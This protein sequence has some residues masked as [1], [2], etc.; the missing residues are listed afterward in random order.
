MGAPTPGGLEA[1]G[2]NPANLVLPHSGSGTQY[3][4]HKMK[5]AASDDSTAQ[6]SVESYEAIR[7]TPPS[8]TFSIIPMLGVSIGSDFINYDIYQQYFTGIDS[9]GTRVSRY[10]TDDDKNTILGVFPNG[11]AETHTDVDLRLFGLT[12]HQDFLG[13]MAFTVTDRVSLNI[14]IP[15]DYARFAFFGLDSLGSTYDFGGTNIR[16]WWLRDYAVSYAR[17][18]ATPQPE[19]GW[20]SRSD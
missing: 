15:K 17:V 1:V 19:S 9:A 10:L 4:R 16:G 12:L 11:V 14:D 20:R 3:I 7:D 18:F 8:A 13:D 2:T 6:D 5:A